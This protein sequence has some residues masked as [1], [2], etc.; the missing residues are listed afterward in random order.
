MQSHLNSGDSSTVDI[1]FYTSYTNILNSPVSITLFLLTVDGVEYE[2]DGVVYEAVVT[3]DGVEYDVVTTGGVE[4]DVVTIGGVEFEAVLLLY[5]ED[6]DGNLCLSD[7]VLLPVSITLLVGDWSYDGL[8][9]VVVA[10]RLDFGEL[11]TTVCLLSFQESL[12]LVRLRDCDLL[13]DNGV[14]SCS[15][16]RLSLVTCGFAFSV[17]L[18]TCLVTALSLLVLLFTLSSALE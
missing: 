14:L 6:S 17:S 8:T 15:L 1:S 2:V 16:L 4:Y 11:G 7:D 10:W 13:T 9:E 5:E 18:C 3:V 12:G